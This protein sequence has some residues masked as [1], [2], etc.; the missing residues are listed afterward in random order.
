MGRE[1]AFDETAKC[2]YCDN[3][4]AFDF[5]GDYFCPDC[6]CKIYEQDTTNNN[7]NS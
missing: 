5:M 1:I 4:G 3:V 2:D 7:D 6:A